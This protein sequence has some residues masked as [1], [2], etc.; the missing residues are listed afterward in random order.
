M[1]RASIRFVGW[2]LIF[3]ALFSFLSS[4]AE[5][6]KTGW[7][8]IKN[9]FTPQQEE[10]SNSELETLKEE[11]ATLKLQV[12]TLNGEKLTLETEVNNLESTVSSKN[13][14]IA[15]LE[16]QIS[17]LNSTLS[18]LESEA[19]NIIE[20]YNINEALKDFSFTDNTAG[21]ERKLI[22]IDTY[23]NL[24]IKQGNK[25]VETI[26]SLNST[27]TT[28]TSEK[29]SL[30]NQVETLTT[31]KT[32]LENQINSLNTSIVQKNNEIEQLNN[33]I[34]SMDLTIREK[35][36]KISSLERTLNT[37]NQNIELLNEEKDDLYWLIREIHDEEPIYIAQDYYFSKYNEL[38]NHIGI[39]S[40]NPIVIFDFRSFLNGVADFD[41]TITCNTANENFDVNSIEVHTTSLRD[42][43]NTLQRGYL[44]RFEFLIKSVD[45]NLNL[46][47]YIDLS[48]INDNC[49]I[50]RVT[51]K[52]NT[53]HRLTVDKYYSSLIYSKDKHEEQSSEYFSLSDYCSFM[54]E[55]S[56]V[57]N[58]DYSEEEPENPEL[59][60]S[61]M[62]KFLGQDE[63]M[64]LIHYTTY[65]GTGSYV[66]PVDNEL[67]TV[68]YSESSFPEFYFQN[69]D[70]LRMENN[71]YIRR[72]MLV[73]TS[74]EMTLEKI[75]QYLA[76]DPEWLNNNAVDCFSDMF[77]EGIRE[78]NFDTD[79]HFYSQRLEPE[80]Y[81]TFIII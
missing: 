13:E 11:N 43:I 80:I 16:Y 58:P 55:L 68:E 18:D 52:D 61:V 31:Q 23:I 45:V 21:L 35:A 9:I 77:N 14:E 12:E 25:N 29:E 46:Y 10:E 27:L 62:F 41:I 70:N 51:L 72:I 37:K 78:Y 32:E 50:Y 48:D 17:D 30:E 53:Q 2:I 63:L 39:D 7:D 75:N 26:N 49:C 65:N 67:I 20:K 34:T 28:L 38:R 64:P 19:D 56:K 71:L 47:C 74:E 3:F 69:D 40:Q 24:L 57:F 66:E 5:Q 81:Y 33:T 6:L 22:K 79:K 15:M 60:Q 36:N 44:Y 42:I 54:S 59:Y 8:K 4:N 1:S 76:E 73:E